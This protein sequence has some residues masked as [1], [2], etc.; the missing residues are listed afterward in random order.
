MINEIRG[1]KTYPVEKLKID[2][3]FKSVIVDLGCGDGKQTYKQAYNNP[4]IF[5]IGID[6]NYKGLEEVSRKARR[7]LAKGGLRN[8][9]FIHG[10]A[11]NLPKELESVADEVQINFPWGSL[12]EGFIN[13]DNN[14]IS[15]I[16]IVAK[17]NGMLKVVTTYDEKYEEKFKSERDLPELNEKYLNSDFKKEILKYGIKITEVKKLT[18]EEKELIESPWGKKILSKRNR[19]V[20]YIVGIVVK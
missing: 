1:K 18:E 14:I 8:I 2:P 10:V 19:D 11:E 17:N 15:N 6:A 16:A 3:S 12:L 5:Y 20:F 7:K 4:G 13:L 9:V